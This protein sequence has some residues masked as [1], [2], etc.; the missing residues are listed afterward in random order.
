MKVS[1]RSGKVLFTGP[2]IC[3]F[4]YLKEQNTRM[5]LIAPAAF[6]AGAG[7]GLHPQPV[8]HPT[9][10]GKL[11]VSTGLFS[12]VSSLGSLQTWTRH[13]PAPPG[14]RKGPA[15]HT[16]GHLSM[17]LQR[18]EELIWHQLCPVGPK[19]GCYHDPRLPAP[20]RQ[21]LPSSGFLKL[22]GTGWEGPLHW[23]RRGVR[24]GGGGGQR[25]VGASQE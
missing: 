6:T 13:R 8:P 19:A 7:L 5:D 23:R 17:V 14:T 20:V 18:L 4:P 22:H 2:Q 1:Q 10:A 12:H 24:G 9:L 3:S 25:G 15:H 11:G 16:A 21:P